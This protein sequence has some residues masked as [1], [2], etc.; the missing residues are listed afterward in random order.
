M[1]DVLQVTANVCTVIMFLI[2][3]FAIIAG[4]TSKKNNQGY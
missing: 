3:V 1:K 2:V 4:M